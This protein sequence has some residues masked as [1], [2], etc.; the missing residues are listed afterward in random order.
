MILFFYGEDD[1]RLKQKVKQLKEKF[2]SASLG[3][4]NLV[5]LDGAK[6]TYEEFIRQILAMPFLAKSRLVIINDLL[7]EGKKE[8]QEKVVEALK[9]VPESTVL[10]LV[11]MGQPDKRTSLYKKLNQ[12][13]IS[14]EFKPMDLGEVKVW[15]KHEIEVR[16]AQIEPTALEKLVEYVGNDL[17]RME[18]EIEK[19]ICYKSM[20]SSSR[21]KSDKLPKGGDLGSRSNDQPIGSDIIKTNDV[22]LLVRPQIQSNIF[23]LVDA[24]ANK[25][26]KRALKELHQLQ[27]NGEH[28]LKIL[29]T[30]VTQ[31]RNLIV[32]R[33]LFDRSKG[34]L[35]Q[36][37]L[38]K[39]VG[40]HPFVAQK[41]LQQIKNFTLEELKNNYRELMECDIAI[42]T[43]KIDGPTAIDLLIV[44][45]C[46]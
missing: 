34:K 5:I 39:A 16:G 35:G 13:K 18:N 8:V 12:P 20:S 36:W 44:R 40:M 26:F 30:V 38:A 15:A 46:N 10:V 25:N 28:E 21:I 22:I 41:T 3:D 11:E 7:K 45:F 33:D 27:D 9:K 29:A 17:W 19:L 1:F 42:K 2:I 4:T 31:Y 14:Q 6:L 32:A 43:G 23:D 24:I 37:D